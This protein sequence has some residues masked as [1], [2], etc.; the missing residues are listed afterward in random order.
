MILF[1]PTDDPIVD[2]FSVQRPIQ[3]GAQEF[4]IPS[5][6]FIFPPRAH[7]EVP[8][9]AGQH[10]LAKWGPTHGLFELRF[11]DDPNEK[12][13]DG[14]RTWLRDIVRQIEEWK[15]DQRIRLSQSI[16]TSEPS[17]SL[18]RLSMLKQRLLREFPDEAWEFEPEAIP[19]DLV[20]APPSQPASAHRVLQ[21]TGEPGAPP[22]IPPASPAPSATADAL[23]A[24]VAQE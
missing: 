8:E 11:G 5:K 16:P 7:L 12:L 10:F 24:A 15:A 3:N 6:V 2:K 1:N 18:R 13:R 20:V 21:H 4:P 19:P 14:R 17:K 9:V 22:P 23:A